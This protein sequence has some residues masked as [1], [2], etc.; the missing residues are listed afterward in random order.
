MWL[1]GQQWPRFPPAS[2][3]LALGALPAASSPGAVNHGGLGLGPWPF[4]QLCPHYLRYNRPAAWPPTRW[5][6]GWPVHTESLARP[7]LW[8][9]H[10]ASELPTPPEQPCAP[11]LTCAAAKFSASSFLLVAG[12]NTMLSIVWMSSSCT[13]HLINRAANN[14]CSGYSVRKPTPMH[15]QTKLFWI[16]YHFCDITKLRKH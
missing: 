10:W 3:T 13:T 14:F 2:L 4:A 8:R 15:M 5:T 9:P 6:E 16:L 7:L 11:R 1:P 12:K